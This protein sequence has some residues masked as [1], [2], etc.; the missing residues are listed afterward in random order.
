MC[1]EEEFLSVNQIVIRLGIFNQRGL[2]NNFRSGKVSAHQTGQCRNKQTK[3][4]D[5]ATR[6]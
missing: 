1:V 6:E 4:V 5:A 3:N 2:Q